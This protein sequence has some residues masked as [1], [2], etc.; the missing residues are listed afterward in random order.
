MSGYIGCAC[1]DCFEI[2]IG[3]PGEM[4]WDCVTEDCQ[5]ESECNA[6]GAYGMGDQS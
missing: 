3:E 1:R 5:P 2:A 6:P 4:C